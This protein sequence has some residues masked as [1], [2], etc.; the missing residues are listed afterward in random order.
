[1]ETEFRWNTIPFDECPAPHPLVSGPNM[2]IGQCP[3]CWMPIGVARPWG[4]SFGWHADDCAGEITHLSSCP[5]GGKGHE[6]P[7]GWKFRG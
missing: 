3:M 4:E 6:V 5:P 1:M 7:E 2:D